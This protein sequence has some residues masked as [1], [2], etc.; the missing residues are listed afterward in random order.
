MINSSFDDEDGENLIEVEEQFDAPSSRVI[1]NSIHDFSEI[2]ST[3][4][5]GMPTDRFSGAYNPKRRKLLTETN[6]DN[7]IGAPYHNDQ[8]HVPERYSE[9]TTDRQDISRY[10]FPY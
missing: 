8:K 9:N 5:T 6:K 7:I 10:V 2:M 4:N 1:S 3:G